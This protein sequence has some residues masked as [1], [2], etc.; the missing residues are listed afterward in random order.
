M[1]RQPNK[2]SLVRQDSS[3]ERIRTTKLPDVTT[4]T[5]R[6]R[7]QEAIAAWLNYTFIIFDDE[8]GLGNSVI[9]FPTQ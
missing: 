1:F 5:R 9:G 2:N 8:I 4:T 6:S 7:W 3:N